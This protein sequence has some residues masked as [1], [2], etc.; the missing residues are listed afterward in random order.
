[1]N[2]LDVISFGSESEES[3][4][5]AKSKQSNKAC[6]LGKKTDKQSLNPPQTNH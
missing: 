1:M 3:V 4:I 5:F 6:F 2:V